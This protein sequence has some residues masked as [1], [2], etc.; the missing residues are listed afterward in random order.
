MRTANGDSSPAPSP[1][2]DPNRAHLVTRTP[3]RS[4]QERT[5]RRN[6]A[7]LDPEIDEALLRVILSPQRLIKFANVC[8]DQETLFGQPNTK[9]R[10]KVQNRRRVLLGLQE[11]DPSA[12]LKLA[13]EFDLVESDSPASPQSQQGEEQVTFPAPKALF[14][15]LAPSIQPTLI[16]PPSRLQRGNKMPSNEREHDSGGRRK[17]CLWLLPLFSCSFL[18]L[19]PMLSLVLLRPA[20]D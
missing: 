8:N 13:K 17:N 7:S 19:T 9:L 1:A 6:S 18:L 3:G 12:F 4:S 10:R 14:R 16:S 20:G 11:K 2:P 5:Q 15:D